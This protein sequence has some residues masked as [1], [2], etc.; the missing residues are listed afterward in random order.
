MLRSVFCSSTS[1]GWTSMSKR[2]AT[3]KSRSRKWPNEIS[4]SGFSQIGSHTV[5]IADSNSSIRVVRGTQ[6]DSTCSSATRR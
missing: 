3:W 5:R 1:C 6:P 2:R 4:D